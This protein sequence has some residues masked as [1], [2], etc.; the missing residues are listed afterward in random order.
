MKFKKI[1][2]VLF[3]L[4]LSNLIQYS[5]MAISALPVGGSSFS[6]ATT[7][8]AGNYNGTI[9]PNS[10]VYY[11]LAIKP[12]QELNTRGGFALADGTNL[13]SLGNLYL[14]DGEKEEIDDTYGEGESLIPYLSKSNQN[15]YVR[16][17][18]DS[19]EDSL[20]YTLELSLQ[21]R[22]DANSLT[23]AGNNFDEAMPINLG[24]Y[25]GY[26]SG[27]S[28]MQT[29]FGNDFKDFYNIPVLK[30]VTYEFKMTPPVGVEGQLELFNNSRESIEDKSSAN[31]DS[32]VS[33]FLTPSS[34]TNV[35]LSVGCGYT[36]SIVNYKIDIISSQPVS[37]YYTCSQG[38]CILAG[39]FISKTACEQAKTTKCYQD[40]SCGYSCGAIPP[41]TKNTTTTK[42][43]VTTTTTKKTTTTTK[44]GGTTTT[45]G[46]E[47]TTT[48]ISTPITII[49][50]TTTTKGIHFG[51]GMLFVYSIWFNVIIGILILAAIAVLI[52]Y[53][54]KPKEKEDYP[55]PVF[56]GSTDADKPT[57]G[58]KHACNYCG[59]LIPPNSTVCPLCG[60]SNP[61]GPGRC[62][63]CHQPI[64]KDWKVCNG[65][66]QNLRIV[67]P[68]CNKIT[69][70]GDYCEDCD[71][72][73]LVTCPHCG[74]EQPP[75]SDKCIKCNKPL[76]KKK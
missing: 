20:V 18:N 4:F 57:V 35:F 55:T 11:Q 42:N 45:K 26:I 22:F 60:K 25:T 36:G 67:C 21:N 69:F 59:K 34:N 6:Q 73:L 14:Y 12:G 37:K 10:D 47:T 68:F 16:L 40:D 9:A 2:I 39:E 48:T 62:P 23:D 32:V 31:E 19:S 66:G 56:S 76:D 54:L 58:Y 75:L 74:Q 70:F 1:F 63:K 28:V 29:P 33:I 52:L 72:R 53:F 49:G 8:G 3:V 7:I 27:V 17:V 38:S 65:C 50:M 5:A 41:T 24:S 46:N 13:Y 30:G 71:A 64:Q 43:I 44:G 15:I 61:L 51:L